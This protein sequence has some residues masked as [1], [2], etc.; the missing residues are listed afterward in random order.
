MV[1]RSQT[2]A[3]TLLPVLLLGLTCSSHGSLV[4]VNKGLKVKRGQSAYLDEGDLQFHIPRQKDACKVEVVLNEPITQRVGRLVPQVFDCHYLTDEV[5]Y[6]HNGCPLLKEDTVKLRLYRFT[7]TETYMEVFSLHVEIIEPEC[8]IIRLGPK[9]LEVPE[10]YSLSDVVDGNVVSFRYERRSSLECSVH[11]INHNS[12]LPAH[13]QLVTGEPEKATKRGDEPESF[14]HLRQQLDNKARAMCKSEDCLK[15]LK[16]VKVNKIPCDDFLSMGLRYQHIEPPSPDIDY[17]P[18]RLDLKD[19]RSGSIYQSEQ[20]WIPVRIIGAMPNQPPKPSFMSMFILEVDQFIL[21]PLSTATLDAEDEETPKQLLVFN[22]TRPPVDGFIAHLSDHTR[23]ISSFTWLDLNDML[24]GYQPPNSSHTQRRNY[25]VEFE[26]HDFFFEKSQ[27]VTVHVSVRNADT[28]APRVSWNMGLSLL[29]GQS[30]PITWDQVQIVDN[31]NLNVVRIITVDGLQ[32]GRLTVRG[33]KGFMFTV[34]DIKAGVVRYHH[35][36]SDST[37]DFIIFRITDGRHQTRH[38][39]PIKILPKDDSPPF[40]IT[41]MLLEVSEGQ[42][43]LL[44]GSTLQASDMDSSDDYVLFNITRPPQAGELMKVPGPGLVGYPVNHF[45]Q[46]DLF[47]S[48]VYYRHLGNKVFDDSFE[49]V[50][51]DFHD[52]PNLSEPQVVLVHIEPVPD[53]PPKEVPGS[54]RCLV[55]KETEVVHITRQELHFLDQE[56]PDSE[57]MYTVTTTP[58]YIGPHSTPDAGRLFLVDSIPK[59][60]KDPNAPVLRLFTQHAVNFMKVAYMPPVTDIGPYPQYIQFILSVTNRLGKTVT[61]ICFN[62]TV[63]PEDNQP[64]QVFTN[65]LSVDEGGESRLGPEHL[66]L[67]DVDSMEEALQVALQREPQHGVLQLGGLPLKPGQAFTVQDLKSFKVSYHHDNS[68][69]VEDNIELTATDGTNSVGFVLQVK[70]KPVNDEVPV[71]VAGLKPVLSC[72]EGEAAVITAEYIFALDA[73]SDNSSLVFLIARQ[74]YHGVVL[75]GGVVVDRFIQADVTAGI[76]SYKHTGLEVG[77]TPRDDTITF[78]IS[79]GETENSAL[80]CGGRNP[81]RSG[82]TVRLRDSLPA[83]DLHITVFPVDNQAPSLKTGDIFTVDE[84][85][86]VPITSSHLKASDVDTVLSELVVSLISPPQFGYIENVLPSP[87]FE[88]SNMGVSIASFSYKDIMDGHVNYVQSRHQ[89]MEPTADHFMLCVSDG[90]HSSAHVPFY[91]IIDPTNDEIPEFM[92][93]N[94]TVREGE[95]KQLD[96]SVLNAVDLDVP[97]NFL[98][99][100]IIKP[101]QHG[102]IINDGSE[103]PVNKR[104][105]A[106]PQS[107]VV[108]FTMTDLTNGMDLMYM[109]DDSENME[110]TFTIQL[111]DGRHQLHRQ[112]TV[113][114]LPVNDEEPRTIRN[115]GLEVEPGE[116][117]LISSVALFAQ[118][119]DTP[120]SEVKYMF[121]SVPTQG[122]LQLKEGQEWVTLTAGRNCTQEMVD[123]N[124]LRYVH[125]GLH[126]TQTQDFFVFHLMDGKNQ[127]PP[128]HF[129]ISV[130]EL[131]KGNIAIFVKP[132]NVSRGDRVVLTTDVLL[133]TDG[134]EKPEELLYVITNPPVHGHVEYIKH[135]GLAISTFS[136]MDI[137]ANLVAYVHDNRASAPKETFQFVVS[138][139]Q[140]SRNGSFEVTVEMVDRVLPSLSS[141]KGV[142]VPQDSSIILGPDSLA[143]SDPDTPPG[144]LTFTILQPPQYGRLILRDAVLT[145]RSNFTYRDIQEMKVS[146]KHGGG[147]S[148]IDRF[149][150]TASDSTS[151]GFLLDG[152]LHVEPVFFTIQ[153]KPL[154]KS[155]PE[156][157]KL[158]PLWKVEVL[159]NG[160][161]G[162]FL[163]SLQLKAQDSD[164][165]EEELTFCIVRP[166][167]FGFLENITTGGFVP[168]CFSQMELNRRTIVYVVSGET[169]SLSDSLEFTV[170]DP[171]G[172]TGSPR[173]LEFSWSSVEL[174]QAQL[175][176][177]EEQG[178]VSLDIVRKGNLAESSYVTVQVKPVT[179]VGSKDFLVSPSSLIQFDPGVSKRTWQIG[180]IQDHL[181]EAE[182][183]FEVLLVS[184][185]ATLIGSISRAQVTI[186]DS[187]GQ[188]RLDRDREAPVLGGKEVKSDAYPQHGSIQ[189][190][191]LPLGSESVVWARGDSI[192][193]PASLPKKKIR[194]TGNPKTIAPSS[195]F[196]NGTD[197]IFTYHGIMQMQV[198]DESSPSR[199]GRKANIRVVSRGPQ[200]QASSAL[201]DSKQEPKRRVST[202]QKTGPAKGLA[203]AEHSIPKPCVPELMGLLHFNQTANRLF[204]CNGVSWKPWSPTDQMVKSQKCPRGWTFHSGHCYIL[205]TEHKATW[206]TANRACRERYKGTLASVLSKVDMDWLWDL[207]GRKPFWIGLNDREGRGHWEWAGGEPVSYTNWRKA[208]TRSKMKGGKK[209]VLVWR[210]AKWQIRDCKTSRGHRFVCSVKT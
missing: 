163:S 36:D 158:L 40:L 195:V 191:K 95:T 160:R 57:L 27:P 63:T 12:H 41:N 76:V 70:V 87:G 148:Q 126:A 132:A 149:A 33:G 37:K 182:E 169:E 78:V 35:D 106:G 171:L 16:R 156:V 143:L 139:G 2:L 183:M 144:A 129:H 159:D 96:S 147:P 86:T 131:E 94:I 208:P 13:G 115:N 49:V 185:E 187:G 21:T 89:R 68:E 90:K 66:L 145:T 93:R 5:K 24:I 190:E 28:N 11:L 44:R 186:M 83:Y 202:T 127:S 14:I 200:L 82:S 109:H 23:P 60:T 204:H 206:S 1:S 118:D 168:Q 3:W 124:L 81:T 39:F 62:I 133:A 205:S 125:T 99:F 134:T 108:D 113:K 29:E 97:R 48:L 55:I 77:L 170:S 80:C 119:G 165:R 58:F 30:R 179:A 4:K 154:D 128:Q 123:M 176:A 56:C 188:C 152:R 178:S 209:C 130:K 157:V 52:P 75:R 102:T 85:G 120:S 180:I 7:E 84:G 150:F 177:C 197:I 54:S 141:N 59:F 198:E 91:I 50:L 25:E 8:S 19:T 111:T 194:V 92:T 72:A 34:S 107:P 155:P 38:K 103:R 20:A 74:P 203:T 110:D 64:P 136:Q 196:H 140:T 174:S 26:V 45:L 47:H 207:T 137:A 142:T 193:R 98:R 32:H 121:E 122:L 192:P 17:I 101:P 71:V 114:V 6:V 210:R 153:I 181:E 175:S 201:T 173:V 51:S 172:N 189:L 146:Y 151:R 104:R 43:A 105:E 73:D 161:H 9:S 100:S 46:K 42:T 65:A 199:K 88:K 162:I 164:S 135:P 79:D 18:I 184:P 53:Q 166:P 67:S 116:M 112:V 15:G 10:F 117:R 69:T 22:I 138:N 31:D 167:Y 61:G